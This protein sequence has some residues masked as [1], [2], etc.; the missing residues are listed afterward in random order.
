MFEKQ[1]DSLSG[2][3]LQI[4]TTR[5]G[6]TCWKNYLHK[7]SP[8]LTRTD[9]K[10]IG[11]TSPVF[12]DASGMDGNMDK[13]GCISGWTEER[14]F[15]YFCLRE[16]FFF[17]LHIPR[18]YLLNETWEIF[19]HAGCNP[20]STLPACVFSVSRHF[21]IYWEFRV[22][23]VFFFFLVCFLPT[24]M[25]PSSVIIRLFF[26]CTFMIHIIFGHANLDIC[27]VLWILDSFVVPT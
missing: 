18:F 27:Q 8:R 9:L 17:F 26:F 7:R 10:M 22:A 5:R 15:T 2:L 21:Y 16:N 14:G 20:V 12:W 11:L 23:L 1:N 4:E 19:L 13:H 6:W 3:G 24:V 25:D